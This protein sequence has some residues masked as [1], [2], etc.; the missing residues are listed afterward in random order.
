[1]AFHPSTAILTAMVLIILIPMLHLSLHLQDLSTWLLR[2]TLSP[3]DTAFPL[4]KNPGVHLDNEHE[5]V[6]SD[7][8]WRPWLMGQYHLGDISYFT[9]TQEP[10]A[11]FPFIPYGN[12]PDSHHKND[13]NPA[14]V[15]R[16]PLDQTVV[17]AEDL[18]SSIR[19]Y[20]TYDDVLT[21]DWLETVI[22]IPDYERAGATSTISFLDWDTIAM[23]HHEFGT[24]Q[25]YVDPTFYLPLSVKF[26]NF[27][28]EVNRL[29]PPALTPDARGP[30]LMSRNS[31][32]MDLF[33]VYRLYSDKYRTFLYGV[34]RA[35]WLPLAPP[36]GAK[37]KALWAVDQW[38]YNLIPVP[39]RLYGLTTHPDGVWGERIAVK[40]ELQPVE[41]DAHRQTSTT[42]TVS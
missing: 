6:V 28:I 32:R 17:D 8:V 27:P 10:I 39:S 29:V 35:S 26:R 4:D 42:S 12:K 13:Y 37:Y 36:G 11:T 30:Y 31:D 20:L 34:Y 7:A 16:V 21:I 18:L 22:L 2:A 23:L 33:P 41:N 25:V 5:L 40:G 24:R 1:M 9:P 38:G 14:T 19:E 15:V 3:T